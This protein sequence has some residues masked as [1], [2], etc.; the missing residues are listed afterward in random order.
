MSSFF[1][2]APDGSGL[3]VSGKFWVF[4]A[5]AIPITIIVVAI[6]TLWIQRREISDFAK[7][8]MYSWYKRKSLNREADIEKGQPAQA[9]VS[10]KS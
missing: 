6:F 3:Q 8:F 7:E 9:S 1:S 4:W 5:F 10:G 2:M